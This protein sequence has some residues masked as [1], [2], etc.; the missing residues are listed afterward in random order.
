MSVASTALLAIG[1]QTTLATELV[2]D[3]GVNAQLEA[4]GSNMRLAYAEFSVAREGGYDTMKT[5][6]FKDTGNKQLSSHWVPG[7]PRPF[8]GP[9]TD[10]VYVTDTADGLANCGGGCMIDS[11]TTT[12]QIVEGMAA[13]DAIRCASLPI[14]DG[15]AFG[16]DLGLVEALVGGFGSS[17]LT[18][19]GGIT[20]GGWLPGE[21]FEIIGGPE[22]GGAT[23]ILGV[24][25]TF[26][27]T[28]DAGNATDI[29][30]DGKTDTA[31]REIYMNNNFA[32]EVGNAMGTG[33]YD[34]VA[35]MNHE[36][37]HALSQG[38]FGEISLNPQGKLIISPKKGD[39]VM[40]AAIG[41]NQ[42]FEGFHGTDKGGH[43]SIWATWPLK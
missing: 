20:H 22:P 28:D 21:F 34:I 43:C 36:Q 38:H 9:T 5:I 39:N 26:I 14:V 31:L 11:A 40:L 35:V 33:V 18:L 17:G 3:I 19:E 13:W 7:D 16:L 29:N 27:W 10:M 8:G 4:T 41:S 12:A 25:F 30:S 37:G 42:L 24:T 32:W 2:G 6:F 23:S 1:A 15:G